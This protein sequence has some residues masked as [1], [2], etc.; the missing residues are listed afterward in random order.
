[1]ALKKKEKR[2]LKLIRDDSLLFLSSVEAR[3]ECI[4]SSLMHLVS[5]NNLSMN[6]PSEHNRH[7]R[8][9]TYLA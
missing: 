1:M 7:M 6:M 9:R 4:H 3:C 5:N 8:L 2:K